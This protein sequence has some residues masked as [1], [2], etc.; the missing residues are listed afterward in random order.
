MIRG[1]RSIAKPLVVTIVLLLGLAAHAQPPY[2]G[3]LLVARG[4]L[5]DPNFNQSVVLLIRH[6]DNGTVGV[7]INR[8]TW[9]EPG[10]VS[11]ELEDVHGNS[12]RVFFGGPVAPTRLVVLVSEPLPD[13]VEDLR[14]LDGVHVSSSADFLL[15]GDVNIDDES[16]LRMYAGHAAWAPGQ[17]A[18]EIA[19][20]A[21]SVVP[22]RS[23]H[24]FSRDPL[25][26][27]RDLDSPSSGLIAAL[28]PDVP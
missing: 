27:W 11:P 17:L 24:V 13:D 20:G 22:G 2:T 21:W 14:V 15:D 4:M 6:N 5:T 12:G 9:V 7:I 10:Q 18:A 26:L 19:E 16:Y 1:M 25:E 3:A 28:A 8:P 23:E